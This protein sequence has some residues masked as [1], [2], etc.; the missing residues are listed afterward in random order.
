MVR[1]AAVVAAALCVAGGTASAQEQ[2]AADAPRVFL[3][4]HFCDTNFIRTEMNW[5]NWVRDAADAQIHVLV[6][7]QSTGGGG[8]EWVL[9]FI[10][11]KEYDGRAD[12]LKYISSQNDSEDTMRQGFTRVLQAGLVPYLMASPLASRVQVSLSK[13][14]SDEKGASAPARDP[15]NF[16][17]FSLG[18]SANMNGQSSEKSGSYDGEFSANRTTGGYKIRFGVGAEYEQDDF[19]LEDSTITSIRKNYEMSLMVVRSVGAHWSAGFQMGSISA[20]FGNI[21][22]GMAGGAAL[23]WSYWP[24][25]DATRRSLTLRY[26]PGLRSFEYR[27]TTIFDKMQEAHPSHTLAAELNLRQRWGST[28]FAA[29][30]NQYLHD[31][32]KYNASAFGSAEVRL[33]K[34]FSVEFYAEYTR[35]RDQL[36]LAKRELSETEVLLRRRELATAY[37]YFGGFGIRYSF[38]SIFNNVVNPRFNNGMML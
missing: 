15:W 37:R 32:Q 26:S 17:V 30:V 25:V 21:S 23:E 16:W 28:N 29:N 7:R 22:L 20:T 11:R 33:F 18:V 19:E 2:A 38:G 4:C 9:N 1:I 10:G 6:T 13:P 14:S 8:Q 5:V 35:V 3:D 36:G 31:F 12:T 27:D 34:G 24:Y